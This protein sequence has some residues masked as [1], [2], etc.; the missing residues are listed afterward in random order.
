[1]FITQY[2]GYCHD[3]CPVHQ[4]KAV[5]VIWQLQGLQLN[6]LDLKERQLALLG[7]VSQHVTMGWD[8]RL[9]VAHE[10]VVPISPVDLFPLSDEEMEILI[11]LITQSL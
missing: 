7:K 11:N 2:V 1:M 6:V 9:E 10:S 4:I 3:V 5:D 8:V